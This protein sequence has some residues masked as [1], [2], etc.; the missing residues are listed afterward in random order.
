MDIK[1][2]LFHGELQE[3]VYLV[4]PSGYEDIDHLDYVSR[5]HKSLYGLKHV[6][7]A[8]HEKI[9]EYLVT[10]SF[11]I[12]N[13]DHSLYVRR[14]ETC[15]VVITIYVDDLIV[16][17]NNNVEVDNVKGLLKKKNEMKELS[18]LRYVFGIEVIMKPKGI[19]LSQR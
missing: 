11:H 12:E 2:A 19:W 15:I 13:V 9:A 8:W 3:E 16:E 5:L 18:E 7:R 4:Q 17:V 1:N 6:P 10:V 14:S